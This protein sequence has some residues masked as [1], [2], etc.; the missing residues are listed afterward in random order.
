MQSLDPSAHVNAIDPVSTST[1]NALHDN[2][3][4][5]QPQRRLSLRN[6]QPPVFQG[7]RLAW[8]DL[9]GLFFQLPSTALHFRKRKRSSTYKLLSVENKKH[10]LQV[11][12]V[13]PRCTTSMH[14]L[15]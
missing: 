2:T 1:T 4:A 13:I 6:N 5:V 3:N 14:Y 15:Y 10:Y 9:F 12:V 8:F 7:D 11:M